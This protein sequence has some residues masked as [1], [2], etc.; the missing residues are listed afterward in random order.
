M[1]NHAGPVIRDNKRKSRK[2]NRAKKIARAEKFSC[3][4]ALVVLLI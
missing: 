1:A 4:Y 2:E 3:Q